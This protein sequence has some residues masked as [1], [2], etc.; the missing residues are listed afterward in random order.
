MLPTRHTNQLDSPLAAH[1]SSP[2]DAQ[3]HCMRY[4][5]ARTRTTYNRHHTI[6][7]IIIVIVTIIIITTYK[8]VAVQT[9]CMGGRVVQ[10]LRRGGERPWQPRNV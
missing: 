9:M 3:V 7:R 10:H 1:L 4:V 2:T 6:L 8:C 5:L